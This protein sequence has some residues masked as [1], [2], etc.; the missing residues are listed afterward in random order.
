MANAQTGLKRRLGLFETTVSG[1]GIILGAGIYALVGEA[2][3]LAGNAV[4][5]S[6]II[7]AAIAALTGLSYAELA[8]MYPNAGADYEYT[9]RGIGARAGFV[10]GWLMVVSNLVGAAAVALGF[11]GYLGIFLDVDAVWLAAAAV[12]G[13]TLIAFAGV[14]EAVWVSIVL[15]FIEAGGLVFVIVVGL[16]DVGDRDLLAGPGVRELFSGAALVT[17]AFIGFGQVAALA[18]ETVDAPR[19]IPRAILLSV[20]VTS[21]LYVLVAIAAVSALGAKSLAASDAPLADVAAAA[22]GGRSRDAVAIVALF[23]TMNTILLMLMASSR[24]IYGMASGEQAALPRFM[25]WVHPGFHTPARAI[26]VCLVV[27]LGF[28]FSGDLGLV[29]GASNF[30]VFVAFMGINLALILLRFRSPE[31]ARPFRVP[32]RIGRVPILPALAFA[33]AAGLM[34]NLKLDALVVGVVLLLFGL[35]AAQLLKLWHHD[36]GSPSAHVS[37]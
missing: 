36:E 7:A 28:T 34:V 35:L 31:V 27:A 2:A 23:S 13:C 14:R 11:G 5:I 17:F 33:T 24:L 25:A 21:V 15:T 37:R 12:V 16:P 22:V 19:V 30:A 9:R 32:G 3:G 29:A 18:E 6:F 8:S 1:I 26:L 20:L 10:V 4:W